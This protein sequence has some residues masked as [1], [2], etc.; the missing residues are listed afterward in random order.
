MVSLFVQLYAYE[1]Y[2][3]QI[4]WEENTTKKQYEKDGR[5]MSNKWKNHISK[6]TGLLCSI[7]VTKSLEHWNKEPEKNKPDHV[8][9]IENG[10]A[11][12]IDFS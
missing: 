6:R 11:V 9:A 10:G 12:S 7:Q 5:R 3:K 2:Q 4:E 1:T 8:E